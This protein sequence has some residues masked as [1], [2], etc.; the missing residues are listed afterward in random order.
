[1]EQDAQPL[2]ESRL[3]VGFVPTSFEFL[4]VLITK[5]FVDFLH[6]MYYYK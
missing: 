2:V 1:M 4:L 6:Y 3:N 5:K